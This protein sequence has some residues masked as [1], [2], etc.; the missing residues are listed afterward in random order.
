MKSYFD[1]MQSISEAV[2]TRGRKKP[3]DSDAFDAR[4]KAR[5]G[6]VM[7]K[8][9]AQ[10]LAAA[11]KRKAAGGVAAAPPRNPFPWFANKARMTAG[12][13]HPTKG[14]FTFHEGGG[15]DGNGYHITHMVRNLSKFGISQAELLKAAEEEAKRNFWDNDVRREK[16]YNVVDGKK[17]IDMIDREEIDNSFPIIYLAYDRGWLRVYGGKFHTGDFGGTIECSDR[18]SLKAAVREIEQVAASEGIDDI[19][20][21][22]SEHLPGGMAGF[23]KMHVLSSKVK[24]DAYMSS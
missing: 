12:W 14:W 3:F 24:R 1:L 22:V 18:K 17:V 20:I 19:R 23:P 8:A 21:D 4:Q 7:A 15:V 5:Y 11:Q 9:A 2:A 16:G 10:A 13:W 6:D